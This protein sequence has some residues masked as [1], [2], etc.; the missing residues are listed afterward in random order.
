MRPRV[1]DTRPKEWLKSCRMIPR[2]LD[3]PHVMEILQNQKHSLILK[4]FDTR[5][6]FQH[7]QYDF[8]GGPWFCRSSNTRG[9][10]FVTCA[11]AQHSMQNSS[12]FLITESKGL[13]LPRILKILHNQCFTTE[14]VLHCG[15]DWNPEESN[16]KCWKFPRLM[17]QNQATILVI[18]ICPWIQNN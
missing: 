1:F 9:H 17:L 16:C 14:S 8:E 7:S 12:G 2:L 4:D 10:T 5:V 6:D 18:W 13:G 11:G 15:S 3:T